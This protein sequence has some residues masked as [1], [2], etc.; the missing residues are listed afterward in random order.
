MSKRLTIRTYMF[1]YEKRGFYISLLMVFLIVKLNHLIWR[2]YIYHD[3]PFITYLIIHNVIEIS[4]TWWENNILKAIVKD[5]PDHKLYHTPIFRISNK[6]RNKRNKTFMLCK[7]N[8]KPLPH[9][10]F[11][12]AR[13]WIFA[14]YS[15]SCIT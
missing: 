3:W 2:G 13:M 15:S 10:K 8:A 12:H 11:I 6:V 7:S 14:G 4:R 1:G 9:I 5:E